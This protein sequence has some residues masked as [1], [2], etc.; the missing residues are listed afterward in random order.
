MVREVK[1]SRRRGRTTIS[2]KHQITLPV[3]AL[4]RAGLATGDRLIVEVRG[5]GELALRLVDEVV[6]RFA[7]ALTG[8][9]EPGELDRLRDEWR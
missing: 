1:H 4:A 5:P 3:D 2:S 7:G 6:D 9:Y 8:V